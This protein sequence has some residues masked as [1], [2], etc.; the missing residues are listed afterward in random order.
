MLLSD[1]LKIFFSWTTFQVKRQSKTGVKNF[2]V[3]YQLASWLESISCQIWFGYRKILFPLPVP[4]QTKPN[5]QDT[6]I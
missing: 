4:T 1:E 6:E 3:S 2:V 5:I